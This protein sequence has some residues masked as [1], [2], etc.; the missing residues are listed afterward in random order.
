MIN[1]LHLRDTDKICG[2]GKTIFETI[3]AIDKKEFNLIIGLFLLNKEKKNIYLDEAI[4]RGIPIVPIRASHQ[5]DPLIFLKISKFIKDNNIHIIHSHEYKSDIIGFF[6]AK[7]HR[8][9]IVTTLH[10]WISNSF[11]SKCYISMQKFLLRYFNVVIAVSSKI[12]DDLIKVGVPEEKIRLIYNAI[13]VEKYQPSNNYNNLLRNKIKLP[14]GAVLIGNIGR[15]S[16][17]KGQKDLLMAA[18]KIIETNQNVYF[19]IIGDGP[20]RSSLEKLSSELNISD[21]VF[22][23]GHL[24]DMREVYQDLDIVALTSHTEGFPNVIL[25]SLCMEKPVIATAVG[26]VPEIIENNITGL[27][28]PPQSPEA[29]AEGIEYLLKNPEEAKVLAINGKKMVL[30]KFHFSSRV[31]KIQELYR[32]IVN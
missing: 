24:K 23:M 25:E 8:I 13:V 28:V 32:G 30:Q 14:Q 19:F 20:D 26:G 4:K 6:L 2:P 17:E 16:P 3:S 18:K 12:R 10:G 5:Y 11:K 31:E 21:K 29:I 1:V 22:F 7:L 9:P 15:L 27:L